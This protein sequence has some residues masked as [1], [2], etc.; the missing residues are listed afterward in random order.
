VCA[1]LLL[2]LWC[3]CVYLCVFACVREARLHTVTHDAVS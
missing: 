3:V 1:F 2:M